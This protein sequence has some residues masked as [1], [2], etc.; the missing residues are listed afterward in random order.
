VRDSTQGSNVATIKPAKC[1]Q[2]DILDPTSC[3]KR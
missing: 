3:I 1:R 2:Y